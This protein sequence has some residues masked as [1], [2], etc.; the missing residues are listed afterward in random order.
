[1]AK[2][3]NAS[4]DDSRNKYVIDAENAMEMARL[5]NQDILITRLMGGL[6]PERT[7]DLE[8]IHSILDIASGPGGWGLGVARTYPHIK[9]VGIDISE[10]MVN[11]AQAHVIARGLH[12]ASFQA[13]DAMQPLK[14][15]DA[16]FDLVNARTLFAVMNAE[17]WPKLL[18]EMMR[19]C[20][21]GGTLRLTEGELTLSNSPALEKFNS[22]FLHAFQQTG[23]TYLPGNRNLGITTTLSRFLTDAGCQHVQRNM[24][25]LD[26]S[27]GT[28]AHEG[29][30]Q[31][32]M[33]GFQLAQPFLVKL[34]LLTEQEFEQLHQ[35]LIAE[36]LSE[37]FC[38]LGFGLTAWGTKP[39]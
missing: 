19:V 11:Y 6:F 30:Y 29:W 36:L 12:N 24:F 27:S 5:L 21:P 22:L 33:I 23:R 20:R 16:S 3:P 9:V 2:S 7:D 10:R 8:G 14:F 13:M 18:Q 32:I 4:D 15:P 39:A 17:T 31:D 35:Q 25:T 26:Y 1:M 28:E 38:G 37:D 34:N